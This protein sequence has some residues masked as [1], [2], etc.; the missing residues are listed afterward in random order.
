MGNSLFLLLWLKCWSLSNTLSVCV[1]L[2]DNHLTHTPMLRLLQMEMLFPWQPVEE[3]DLFKGDLCSSSSAAGFLAQFVLKSAEAAVKTFVS[4]SS[5]V[6]LQQNNWKYYFQSEIL[7]LS[8]T[9]CCVYS[10]WTYLKLYP[11]TDQAALRVEAT[12]N[13]MAAVIVC[14]C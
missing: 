8:W 5:S 6:S 4:N 9:G 3:H 11:E 7:I 12:T 13:K 14:L 10:L 1:N 2:A